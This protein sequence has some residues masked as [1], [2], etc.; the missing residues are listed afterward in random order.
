MTVTAVYDMNKKKVGEMELPDEVFNA[1]VNDG[2]IHEA[3][4][5]HLS[6]ARQGTVCTKTRA[7]VKGGG[8]KPYKQ[9]GTGQARHGSIRSPIFVGGGVPF[10]PKPRDWEIAMPKKQRRAALR[11][12]LTK[13]NKDGELFIVDHFVSKDGKTQGIAKCMKEWKAK[14]SVIVSNKVDEKTLR[15]VKNLP[16]VNVVPDKNLSVLDL[17]KYENILVTKDSVGNLVSR[18]TSA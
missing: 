15:A 8:R 5:N 16:N 7:M 18:I 14:S 10:G 9:K 4:I 3:V 6:N 11:M 12:A 13:K 2:L 1:E 17:V